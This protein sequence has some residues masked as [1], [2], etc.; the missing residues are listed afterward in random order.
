MK[1]PFI[2][3]QTVFRLTAPPEQRGDWLG[4]K[5]SVR[6]WLETEEQKRP[7]AIADDSERYAWEEQPDRWQLFADAD[8]RLLVVVDD[9]GI[10]KSRAS[11]QISYARQH[12]NT[13]HLVIWCE[14]QDLPH[15]WT[16]YFTDI[17]GESAFL[18]RS[19]RTV[20]GQDVPDAQLDELL[21]QKL[22]L[23]QL[24]LI[25][26]ALDQSNRHK[27]P[28]IAARQL[29]QFL[30]TYPD[31]KCVV[32]GR[33][34]AVAHYWPTL[35]SKC[36]SRPEDQWELVQ[37]AEFTKEQSATFVGP[38]LAKKLGQLD[39]DVVTT[40]RDLET[41]LSLTP[42]ELSGVKTK[43][44]VY[45]T[46]F[47]KA[48]SK[49]CEDQLVKINA[50][51]AM[52]LFAMLAFETVSQGLFAD[53]EEQ[54]GE[55]QGN[56]FEKF[57]LDVAM[58][59]RHDLEA[60]QFTSGTAP[61][62][63][64]GQLG[65]LNLALDPGILAVADTD[66]NNPVLRQ[67]KWH[68]RTQQDFLAALWLV[69]LSTP[70]DRNWLKQRKFV[71]GDGD[72]SQEHPEVYQLWRFVCEM[73]AEPQSSQRAEFVDIAGSLL[74]PS[75]HAEFTVRSTEMIWRCWP[76][77]LK[78]AGLLRANNWYE[79]DLEPLT[80]SLQR[81]ARQLL[82]AGQSLQEAG[83]PAKASL[84]QFVGE[85]DRIRL[86]QHGGHASEEAVTAQTFEDGFRCCPPNPA[87][88]LESWFGNGGY[89]SWSEEEDN[90]IVLSVEQRFQL[91]EVPVTN[92]VYSLFDARHAGRFT[93]YSNYSPEADCPV[94][95]LDW[96]SAWT[97]A[98]CLGGQLPT[99]F[100]WEYAC[101]ASVGE[102]AERTEYCFGNSKE[103]LVAY[104]SFDDNSGNRLHGVLPTEET[105]AKRPNAWGLYHMHGSV[106]EW[107]RN[108]WSDTA[109]D[110]RAKQYKWSSR[111]VRGGSFLGDPKHCRS[112]YRNWRSPTNAGP[113]VG[114][115]VSRVA[116]K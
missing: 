92:S 51:M 80:Q 20:V 107:C 45:W 15:D 100:Q 7:E 111:C 14:F 103:T 95:Y 91:H 2:H 53:V 77:M 109:V 115:R 3:D 76:G 10:G 69:S 110:S 35:F 50:P 33:P 28:E 85:F 62:S 83:T 98:V 87:D 41:L 16:N 34:F 52:K 6:K 57:I 79:S 71:R 81:E 46:C 25:V 23:G 66:P 89:W 13:S 78:A 88:S 43:A 49:A 96:Y 31:M 38:E 5:F 101:R 65:A 60:M 8:I 32:A 73:P 4:L 1:P 21:R 12:A 82:E 26:D 22:R 114:V 112:A 47:N 84:L 74:L 68:D 116:M 90:P 18:R 37:L 108:W 30:N 42:E 44:D 58:R 72:A 75:D 17:S 86:A 24:T 94:N 61:G 59:R 9:A 105:E 113:S 93:E 67:L 104:A 56:D 99:E 55:L 102:E 64:L 54:A 48:L 97:V 19:L 63:L 39:A 27:K 70:E 106:W 11:E 36:G 29:A 40:P